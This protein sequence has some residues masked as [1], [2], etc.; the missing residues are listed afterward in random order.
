VDFDQS[1]HAGRLAERVRELPPAQDP[2]RLPALIELVKIDLEKQWQRGHRVVLESYLQLYPELGTPDTIGADLIYAEHRIKRQHDED[3][4]LTEFDRRF[5]CQIDALRRFVAQEV[6]TLVQRWGPA[7]SPALKPAEMLPFVGEDGKHLGQL[8][9]YQILEKLGQGGMGVVMRAHDPDFGRTLAVKILLPRAAIRAEG[10][11]RFL[12]EARITGQ[13][14]HPGIPPIH[15]LGRTGNGLPFFTMKLISGRTLH[16]LLREPGARIQFLDIFRQVCQTIAHAHSRGVIHRDLKS[17]NVMVGAFG[18]V[19][20]MDWGLAKVLTRPPGEDTSLPDPASNTC[21]GRLE[22]DRTLS[23]TGDVLE[24]LG[25]MA[26][27]QARGEI[28]SLD[29]RCDVFGLGALL[30]EGLTGQP[31]FSRGSGMERHARASAGDLSE[32]F[33]RLDSCGAEAELIDLARRCLAPRTEDRPRHAGEVAEAIER[34][35]AGVQERLRQA[36]LAKAQAQVQVEEERRRREVEQARALAEQAKLA[37][38]RRRRRATL[39]AAA[40]MLLL[41]GAAGTAL[42]YQRDLATRAAEENQRRADQ[43]RRHDLG[44]QGISSALE[45][46]RQVRQALQAQLA[47]DGSVFALLDNPSSWKHQI[48]LAQEALLRARDLESRAESPVSAELLQQIQA[49]QALLRQDD[50]DRKLALRLEKVREDM[51]IWVDGKFDFARADDKYRESFRK[52]AGP[53]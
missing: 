1:W 3:P 16:D 21:I 46:A 39:V 40:A 22:D 4:E 49:L 13:L 9:R 8:G 42:W 11:K 10:Q 35:Q 31:P 34:Y 50:A 7:S 32:A 36:E 33:A 37:E 18:E 24:T 2:L 5:P 19:L 53:W 47:R 43:Q 27:E 41:A 20:V 29:E 12:E 26:P 14:Q 48:D 6:D 30:C 45:Q 15:E 51:W 44:E 23:E 52:W 38:E 25:Y 28:G 17:N